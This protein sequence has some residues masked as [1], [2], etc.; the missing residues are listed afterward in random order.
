MEKENAKKQRRSFLKLIS[1][2]IIGAGIAKFEYKTS[3]P[4]ESKKIKM[5]TPEGKLV[6]IDESVY[7]QIAATQQR[8]TNNEVQEWMKTSKT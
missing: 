6:E 5:L 3:Q 2:V 1:A 4:K 8:A 7:T